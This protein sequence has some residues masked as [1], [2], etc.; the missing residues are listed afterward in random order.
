MESYIAA[1]EQAGL[2][3][4]GGGGFPTGRK[5]RSVSEGGS[6][7]VVLVN[8]SEGEPANAKDTLLMTRAPHLVLDG[9]LLA[10]VAVGAREI[11][12][13]HPHVDDHDVRIGLLHGG[14]Q[15]ARVS[16]CGNDFGV[17]LGE[18]AGDALAVTL[19]LVSVPI[20][21]ALVPETDTRT[22]S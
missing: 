2:R 1:A 19:G 9:A 16:E 17:V 7:P 10:A 6:R 14:Q 18:Q 3:G 13:G 11:V 8:G 5:L 12:G 21:G 4:R 15:P 22:R 20:V